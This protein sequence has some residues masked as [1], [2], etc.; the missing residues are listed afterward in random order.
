MIEESIHEKSPYQSLTRSPIYSTT[1][2]S[3]NIDQN[4]DRVTVLLERLGVG[5]SPN[6]HSDESPN[7]RD[8]ESPNFHSDERSLPHCNESPNPHSDQNE[9]VRLR[10]TNVD[11]RSVFHHSLTE[12]EMKEIPS[13]DL[14]TQF[15][16]YTMK[17]KSLGNEEDVVLLSDYH[18]MNTSQENEAYSE[19]EW[20]IRIASSLA[21]IVGIRQPK[22]RFC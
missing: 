8:R 17:K 20:G 11:L 16:R 1:K 15:L 3:Q 7:T 14:I 5:K 4:V 12:K 18:T 22:E 21:L 2:R 9:P 6:P 10:F 13:G 19:S